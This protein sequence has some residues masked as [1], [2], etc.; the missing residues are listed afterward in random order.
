MSRAKTWAVALGATAMATTALAGPVAAAEDGIGTRIIGGGPVSVADH[1]WM[2]F[3]SDPH[4]YPQRPSNHQCGGALV[5]PTKVVTAA[6]CVDETRLGDLDVVGGRTDLRTG[7]GEVR[8]VVAIDPHEKVAGPP[9][10]EGGQSYPGGDIAVLTLDRPMPYRTLPVATPEQAEELYRPGTPAQVLGWGVS[11]EEQ[12]GAPPAESATPL[13]QEAQL[14][15]MSDE[16]C[17]DAALHGSPWPVAFHPEHYV[18]AGYE[19]GGVASSGGDSGGP[20]VVDGKL[21]GVTA[22][23]IPRGAEPRLAD[24]LTG[25]TRITTFH[26]HV[27]P[28]L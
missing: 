26:D 3:L 12:L 6:H 23:A 10:P 19:Q 22:M 17:R 24:V 11:S 1:P 7:A 13:L 18:C 9:P 20:L 15:L 14:P 28:H 16:A 21:V 4:A 25:Y 8:K 2:V 5:A 27:A